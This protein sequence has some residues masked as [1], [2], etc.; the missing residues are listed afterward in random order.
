MLEDK[1]ISS[2]NINNFY[3]Y[4]NR[5]FSSRS[6]V[7]PLKQ[8]DGSLIIDPSLKANLLQSVFSSMFTSDNG[9]IPP[10][11]AAPIPG[12]KISNVIFTTN[13]VRKAII[14]LRANSKGG[15]D[16]LPP[17]F[18]KTCSSQLST[19]LAY[20]YN[21]CMEHGYLAPDWL[22]AYITPV[23]KKGMQPTRSITDQFH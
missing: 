23:Y 2:G 20:I 11:S 12:N 13:L 21:Q 19:P 7:G 3:R 10:L 16:G 1:I 17:I 22:R 4:A 18:L 15:P 5:R 9:C 6:P 8:D 14:K